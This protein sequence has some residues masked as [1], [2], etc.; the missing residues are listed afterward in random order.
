MRK[1]HRYTCMPLEVIPQYKSYSLSGRSDHRSDCLCDQLV[2]KDKQHQ[3]TARRCQNSS[4]C[5]HVRFSCHGSGEWKCVQVLIPGQGQYRMMM[6]GR[7]IK[8]GIG[9]SIMYGLHGNIPP[10]TWYI[11]VSE[12]WNRSFN[13]INPELT[14]QSNM[15]QSKARRSDRDAS[16][17]SPPPPRNRPHHAGLKHS[18]HA[19]RSMISCFIG[20]HQG[21]TGKEGEDRSTV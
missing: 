6:S 13:N 10:F 5:S 7:I 1:V 19:M 14:W 15:R 17:E 2:K 11:P 16:R 9:L 4:D 20:M 8:S 18:L 21:C 12:E 3:R